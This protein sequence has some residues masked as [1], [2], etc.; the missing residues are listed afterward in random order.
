MVN[1][2]K[3]Q[4]KNPT[5]ESMKKISQDISDGVFSKVYLLFGEETY[6]INQYR[7]MLKKALVNPDDTMNFT[8]Y[9]KDTF[10]LNSVTSD[11]ITMPFLAEHRVVLAEN[12]GIFDSSDTELLD[13]V[14]QMSDTNV[15]I[16]C[17]QKVDK[18]KKLYTGLSKME[19]TACLEFQTPDIA[20]LTKWVSGI[21][22]EDGLRIKATVPDL[23]ISAAGT[24]MNM[25]R[26][27]AL[28][29]HDYCM[30]KGEITEAD[31]EEICKS[32]L[33]DKI[34]E[35]CEAIAKKNKALA[36]KEFS[37]L[38]AL[39]TSPMTIIVL[40][41]REYNQLA[42]VSQILKE[43]GNAKQVATTMGVPEFAARKL[44][45]I[46]QNYEHKR[47]LSCLDMCHEA[48]YSV[49]TGKYTDKNS[50]E[51]LILNLMI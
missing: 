1:Q 12:T 16:F 43:N 17:E 36:I 41:T 11:I 21:L 44:I 5:T 2:F 13:A 15:L 27:E 14:S 3:K 51:N 6:L 49:V 45:S 39:N 33:E 47:L 35:M 50:A 28:K 32:P 8:S 7:D 42:Q 24:N 34:F 9:S 10:N 25:L 26:N 48:Y 40:V 30:E 29:L 46:A 20:T 37:D 31:V 4:K 23:L 19:N 38:E 22:S 18:R